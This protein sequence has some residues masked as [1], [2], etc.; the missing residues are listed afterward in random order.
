MKLFDTM[1]IRWLS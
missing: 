1:S